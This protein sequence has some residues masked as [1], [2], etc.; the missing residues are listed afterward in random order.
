[1]MCNCFIYILDWLFHPAT[2]KGLVHQS[3]RFT[4]SEAE[5]D[6]RATWVK[7]ALAESAALPCT[8][9]AVHNV[10]RRAIGVVEPDD[11][12]VPAGTSLA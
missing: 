12:D 11:V 4:K 5:P 10:F 2:G 8:G 9:R 3:E 7:Q 6:E 1:M